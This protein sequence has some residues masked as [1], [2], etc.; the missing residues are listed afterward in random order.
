MMFIKD[1]TKQPYR[2]HCVLD[3]D[4]VP[5]EKFWRDRLKDAKID[6]MYV[7]IPSE[8]VRNIPLTNIYIEVVQ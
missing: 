8:N 4:G 2:I 7:I 3:V 5:C 1:L 6:G